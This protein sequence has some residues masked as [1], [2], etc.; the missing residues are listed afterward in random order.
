MLVAGTDEG[1]LYHPD[2]QAHLGLAMQ[3]QV[4]MERAQPG[5][6]RPI[7]LCRQRYNQHMTPGSLLVEFGA[8]GDTLTEALAAADV[9]ADA[10]AAL[11]QG[12]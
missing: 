6:T 8:A 7:S 3:L 2:W 9:F 12:G 5:I 4:L 10:L 11:L 1:G